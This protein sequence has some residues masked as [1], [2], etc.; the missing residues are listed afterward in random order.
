MNEEIL[1]LVTDVTNRTVQKLVT[2]E[3]PDLLFKPTNI[4]GIDTYV[5]LLTYTTGMAITNELKGTK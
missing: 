2:E 3:V 4:Q 5:E 1:K